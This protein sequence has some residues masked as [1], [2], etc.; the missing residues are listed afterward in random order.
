LLDKNVQASKK[1]VKDAGQKLT[2]NGHPTVASDA[3]ERL[4]NSIP[5]FAGYGKLFKSS[6]VVDLTEA[7]IEYGVS[8]VK[9]IYPKHVVFQFNCTN[10]I[11]EQILENVRVMM[12]A[13]EAP[14]FTLVDS[15]SLASLPYGTAGQAFVSFQR[16]EGSV[17]VGKFVNTCKVSFCLVIGYTLI[18][19]SGY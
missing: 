15:K 13:T 19:N 12:D 9:H 5:D 8:A 16:P 4:L 6:Q 18:F 17:S 3:Y 14:D 2:V 10:T 11:K 7:E 1:A